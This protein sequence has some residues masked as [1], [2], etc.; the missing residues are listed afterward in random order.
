VL[1][2]MGVDRDLAQGSL[3][4]TLGYSSTAADVDLALDA[5][6]AAVARLRRFG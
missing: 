2:A 4:L 1:A 5:V 3:R 6:P